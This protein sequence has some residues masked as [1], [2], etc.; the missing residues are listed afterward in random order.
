MSDKQTVK[1]GFLKGVRITQ[2]ILLSQLGIHPLSL[3]SKKL[4]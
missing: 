3:R 2:N 4:Q 1:L